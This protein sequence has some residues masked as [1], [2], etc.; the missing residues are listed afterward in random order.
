M[1][2]HH[3]RLHKRRWEAVRRAV[4]ERDGWRCVLCGGAG[5][6]EA[7]HINPLEREPGQDPYD[8]NGLQTLCAPCHVAKTA[9]ENR[10]ELT[11]AELAWRAFVAELANINS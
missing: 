2:R 8:W 6:L 5:R 10:R 4:F 11:P 9:K 1:S 7:D 3:A